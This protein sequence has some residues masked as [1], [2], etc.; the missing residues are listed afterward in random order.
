V[1][2]VALFAQGPHQGEVDY[3]G[4]HGR[5]TKDGT[6]VAKLPGVGRIDL[7][8]EPTSHH[9]VHIGKQKGCTSART[10][11]D[12]DGVFRGTIE[13]HG[14]G[15]FTT[16][17]A[18]SVR[19]ELSTYP[20]QTCRVRI[21]SKAQIKQEIEAAEAGTAAGE[22][23]RIEDLYA[24]R[25][26]S[27]G[28]LSFEATSFPTFF[29]AAPPRQIEFTADYSRHRDG[30]WVDAKTRV[31]GAEDFTVSAPTG[32]PSEAT[33]EPP[34]PF[35]GSAHFTLESPTVA[36]WTGD[37]RVP[38]PTLGTVDLTGPKFEPKLCDS[39]GCTDT[40]PGSHV[41]VTVVGSFGGTF[42]G[43]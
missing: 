5:F 11:T 8:Y 22:G 34:A 10:T 29:K 12:S 39:G 20:K 13:L 41:E 33:V 28:T 40:A 6:I 1:H 36:S 31:E 16:V 9:T 27:G 42:Y 25:K 26:L 23:P 24:F 18:H 38:I 2:P 15:G 14:E 35:A 19:G 43:E 37:L 3:Q 32:S 4:F 21:P 7:R 17:I 30:M